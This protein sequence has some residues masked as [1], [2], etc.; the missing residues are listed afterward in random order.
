MPLLT[1]TERFTLELIRDAGTALPER[2][3]WSEERGY[4]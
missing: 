3:A 4:A 2:L 1:L